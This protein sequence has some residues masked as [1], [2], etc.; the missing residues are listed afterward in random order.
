MRLLDRYIARQFLKNLVLLHV[1]LFSFVLVI[2]FSL[3]FDE[4]V[5]IARD[6]KGPGGEEPSGVRVALVSAL[7]V[8]DLWWPRLFQLFNYLLGIMLVGAMAFT[9]SQMV[10]NREFVAMLASGQSLLRVARPMLLCAL[11]MV[12]IQTVNREFVVPHLAE[13][14]T[15]SKDDAGKRG[16][17]TGARMLTADAQ[18]RLFYARSF[19][20]KNGVIDGLWV[21]ERDSEG[22]MARRITADSARWNGAAW[23]LV[24]GMARTRSAAVGEGSPINEIVTDL[25]P[26]VLK[27][28]RYEGYSDNLSTRQ[29][30]ELI[31]RYRSEA[32][33]PINRI[34]SLERIR[35][36]RIATMIG[37]LLSLLMCLPFFLRREPTNMVLQSLICSPLALA[38][39]MAGVLGAAAAIPGL[40]PQFSV[41]VPVLVLLPLAIASLSNVKT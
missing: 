4:Y 14:L 25:S 36:G 29:I 30:S 16:L 19:D 8:V 20:L 1:V 34:D 38:A 17:A 35:F 13:L 40:P 2:D 26:T 11:L 24:N 9:C 18:G 5:S 6:M 10:R 3:N 41:F 39:Q 31:A 12:G 37:S 23:K 7:L 22:L 15:R 21:W 33:P 27:L 28:R 32:E